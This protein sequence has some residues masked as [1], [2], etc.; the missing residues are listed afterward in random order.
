MRADTGYRHA[1]KKD[2][3]FDKALRDVITRHVQTVL[4][5]WVLDNDAEVRAFIVARIEMNK[6]EVLTSVTDDLFKRLSGIR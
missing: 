4:N 6:N 5:Q 3:Y 1:G 2:T